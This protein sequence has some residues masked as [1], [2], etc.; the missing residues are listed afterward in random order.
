MSRV[1]SITNKLETIFKQLKSCDTD[2]YEKVIMNIELLKKKHFITKFRNSTTKLL[3]TP[4][5][6]DLL[7]Y[8]SDKKIN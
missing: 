8:K 1:E 3:E 2:E 4:S 7:I 5:F 6:R